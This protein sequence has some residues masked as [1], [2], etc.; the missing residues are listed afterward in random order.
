MWADVAIRF[1]CHLQSDT[2]RWT[3]CVPK[4]HARH[5]LAKDA[6]SHA[7]VGAGSE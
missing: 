3:V 2:V 6:D 4:A 7:S 1:F 5:R